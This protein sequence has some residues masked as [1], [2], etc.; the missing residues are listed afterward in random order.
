ML[1]INYLTY[2]SKIKVLL[3]RNYTENK[4]YYLTNYF[5]YPYLSAIINIYC[6]IMKKKNVLLYKIHN[7]D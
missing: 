2:Y 3:G 6:V 1:K 4:T 5:R 7:I